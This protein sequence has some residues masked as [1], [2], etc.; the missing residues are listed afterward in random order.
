ME[1][2]YE[3]TEEDYI[4]FQIHHLYETPS[5]K[6][7]FFL[8]RYVVIPFIAL[9]LY[10][11][12]KNILEGLDWYWIIASPLFAAFYMITYPK[13]YNK[14]LRKRLKKIMNEGDNSSLYGKKTFVIKED[15]IR[16]FDEE[17]TQIILKKA[18]KSVTIYEDMILLYL[19]G[20]TAHII[21][22]RYLDEETI[23]LLKE[24]FR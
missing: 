21:P 9:L 3:L 15:Q 24:E 6:K 16:I 19:S 13:Q 12:G 7:A 2:Q 4:K 18:V 5:Q 11:I 10:F 20:I 14:T 17:V 8:N 1:I 22:T 23:Q